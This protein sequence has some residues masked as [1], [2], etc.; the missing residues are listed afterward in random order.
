MKKAEPERRRSSSASKKSTSKKSRQQNSSVRPVA[1]G[2]SSRNGKQRAR[3]SF[4]RS[5]IKRN[6]NGIPDYRLEDWPCIVRTE[7]V[8]GEL[9]YKIVG[10]LKRPVPPLR[11]SKYLNKQQ[12]LE[13]Y[14]FMLMH[15]R[16]EETLETLYKQSKVVGGVYFGLGQEGCSVAS[17]YALSPDDWL[18]P[19][20]RNQGAYLV[21]GFR[22]R[23]TMLQYMAK[24]DSPTGGKESSSA[25]GDHRQRNILAPV[26]HLGDSIPALAGVALGARLQGKNIACLTYIG[27]GG[28]STGSTYEG[29]NFAAVQKLGVI[30]LVENNL[31]AYS[32]PS[33]MQFACKDL[34]DR[35]L[36]YGV[37]GAIVDGTDANQ[38]YDVVYE[39]V[40]RAHRGEGASLIEAKMLRMKGH[41]IH[42]SA[43]YVPEELREYWRQRDP[44]A[45]MEKYLTVKGWLTSAIQN[46]IAQ[47]VAR[48]I[49]EDRA[50]S[51][52]SP[53][54]AREAAAQG[55]YCDD[56][57][58]PLKYGQP[59]IRKIRTTKELKSAGGLGHLS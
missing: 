38:V 10:E 49:E 9:R 32:T 34:A 25:F 15:R 41:A 17:A 47:E 19:M 35:S 45:R 37:P 57:E 33:E 48:I 23:D 51:E 31:W 58:L 27:D 44:I 21:R 42:D 39:A 16:V 36:G 46:K 5:A 59:R 8:E 7:W 2:N 30:V 4:P 1:S 26:S 14:R 24:A 22:P 12:S 56:Q 13:I 3:V 28:Q 29:F 6:P 50:F 53:M 54:P 43:A 40:Q 20:I 52:A 11:E 55:V 18:G